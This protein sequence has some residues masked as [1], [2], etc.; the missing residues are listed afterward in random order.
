MKTY[1]L[2]LTTF[3]IGCEMKHDVEVDEVGV[4]PIIIQFC[5]DDWLWDIFENAVV[6]EQGAQQ[7]CGE[8]INDA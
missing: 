4:E 7:T 3:L 5:I 6:D 8:E 2:I 1:V